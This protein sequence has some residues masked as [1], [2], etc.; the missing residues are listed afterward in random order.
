MRAAAGREAIASAG[1]ELA[2]DLD[3]AVAEP[4]RLARV[5]SIDLTGVNVVVESLTAP[6]RQWEVA[7]ALRER[8]PA[9]LRAAGVRLAY[10]DQP[11]PG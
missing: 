5:E 2:D 7:S 9:A 3:T 11:A 6:G 1:R 8:L 10:G 4:P